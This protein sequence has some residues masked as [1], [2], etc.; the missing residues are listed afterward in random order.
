LLLTRGHVS[1]QASKCL[2]GK[3]PCSFLP[4][5]ACGV[6]NSQNNLEAGKEWP[7]GFSSAEIQASLG[8]SEYQIMR[9]TLLLG[10]QE[11]IEPS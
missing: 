9:A 2:V 7:A 6:I 1:L 8:L 10:V 3:W 11:T 4:T 5:D